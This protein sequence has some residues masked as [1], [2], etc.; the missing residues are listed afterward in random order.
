[1]VDNENLKYKFLNQFDKDM[2]SFVR[3]YKILESLPA[4]QLN[5]DD[6]NK[7]IIFERNNLIFLFNFHPTHSIP[8]YGFFAPQ[9]G[10]YKVILN[11]DEAKYGGFDRVDMDMVYPVIKDEGYQKLSIYLPN[12]TA[13]VLE[14]Q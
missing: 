14:R 1:L 6:I 10:Q 5:M 11:S 7:A 4:R 12:R 13:L 3:K 8:D 2:I 9:D